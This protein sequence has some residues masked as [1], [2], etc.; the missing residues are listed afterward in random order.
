MRL[1]AEDDSV[2]RAVCVDGFGDGVAEGLEPGEGGGFDDGFGKSGHGVDYSQS[3]AKLTIDFVVVITII[4][5][6]S[7]T[8]C[9]KRSFAAA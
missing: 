6:D 7:S 8:M 2:S 1:G 9:R 3:R 4:I 5:I